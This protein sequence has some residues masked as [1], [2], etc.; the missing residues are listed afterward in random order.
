MKLEFLEAGEIVTTHGVQ[1]EMKVLPWVDSP[2]ILCE[3][4]RVRIAGSNFKAIYRQFFLSSL[5]Q[6]SSV[7]SLSRV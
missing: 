7:Q 1:G 4:D 6:F 5:F 3:F 2:D